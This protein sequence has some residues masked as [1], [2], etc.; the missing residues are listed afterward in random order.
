MVGFYDA[1]LM[2][3]AHKNN[4][5]AVKISNFPLQNL[6]EEHD[7]SKWVSQEWEYVHDHFLDGI[8]IDFEDPIPKDNTTVRFGLRIVVGLS[9]VLFKEANSSYQV[10]FDIAWSPDCI[11]GRCYDTVPMANLT[12]FLF[13]MAYDEQSQ[14]FGPD[15]VAGPNSGLQKTSSGLKRFLDLGIDPS[16]L[17]LGVP[18]Y[19]YKYPCVKRS[20]KSNRTTCYIKHVPFRGVNCSDAAGSQINYKEI[21]ENYLPASKSGRQWDDIAK[22]PFFDYQD[23]ATKKWSQFWYDDPESLTYKY[24]YAQSLGLRG[25]GMWNA[26]TLDYSDTA[27]GKKQ[28][29][30]MWGALPSYKKLNEKKKTLIH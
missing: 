25:V 10:T 21:I 19:G 3:H 24:K 29:D 30:Q 6:T 11:D 2:C 17:V 16:K 18:W 12:D 22:S 23:P 27:E 8:N 7:I 9:Y 15:C 26:D 5:R 14:I 13:V 20:Q 4:A 28:R 1:Q